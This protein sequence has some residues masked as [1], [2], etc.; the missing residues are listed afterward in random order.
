MYGPQNTSEAKQAMA[1]AKRIPA[2]SMILVDPSQYY[3]GQRAGITVES[4]ADQLFSTRQM[5]WLI[6]ER[7]AGNNTD[8]GAGQFL[9]AIAYANSL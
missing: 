3:I 4:S 5:I 8:L 9:D 2:G 6:T 1:I 7:V